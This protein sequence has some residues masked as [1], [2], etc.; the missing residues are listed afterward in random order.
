MLASAAPLP[1]GP[2][3]ALAQAE[4]EQISHELAMGCVE[5]HERCP[6]CRRLAEPYDA[7]LPT[8]FCPSLKRG[9]EVAEDWLR[10]RCLQA[11]ADVL[12]ETLEK[13]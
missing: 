11:K 2:W 4:W 10:A 13:C 1:V 3:N 12:R 9:F 7:G 8:P 6:E 5:H